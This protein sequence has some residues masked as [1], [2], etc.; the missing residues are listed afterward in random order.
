[1]R[2]YFLILAG[3]T[4]AAIALVVLIGTGRH[5]REGLRRPVDPPQTT[6]S[7]TVTDQSWTCNGPVALDL[8]KVTENSGTGAKDAV[9]L[10]KNCTGSIGR[11][12]V[13]TWTGDGVKVQNSDPVAHDLLI[14][15]GY[16]RCHDKEPTL[17]QDGVQA[18]GGTNILFSGVALDCGRADATLVD[19]DWFVNKSGT[20]ASTPT[21]VVCDGC[22]LGPGP[23]AHEANV[24]ESLRSGLRNSVLCPDK[25]PFNG[26][27]DLTGGAVDPVNEGNVQPPSSDSRC[28]G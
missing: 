23:A 6:G 2:P 15:G 27:F 22:T 28:G 13:D 25:T 26:S 1:M 3:V 10:G 24:G 14:G 19:A 21:D 12:E 8:V 20:G 9:Y 4:A 5:Q 17:H 18:M 7:L 16:V 11:I